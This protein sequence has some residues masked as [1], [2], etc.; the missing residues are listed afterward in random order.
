MSTYAELCRAIAQR[1]YISYI[2]RQCGSPTVHISMS[3]RC[4]YDLRYS[5]EARGSHVGEF[6]STNE[7]SSRSVSS[8]KIVI[9]G[10]VLV[11]G[12]MGFYPLV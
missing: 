3:G 6:Y 10:K 8:R 9:F 7:V 11:S 4:W 5:W 12:N 1:Q 2:W